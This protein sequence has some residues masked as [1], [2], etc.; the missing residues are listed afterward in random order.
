MGDRAR[1]ARARAFCNSLGERSLTEPVPAGVAGGIVTLAWSLVSGQHTTMYDL[2][3]DT[4][5]TPRR[6]LFVWGCLLLCTGIA[7]IVYLLTVLL[8]GTTSTTVFGVFFF[9][10]AGLHDV[11]FD[12][13][14]AVREYIEDEIHSHVGGPAYF[15]WPVG[16]G[17]D[18]LHD[19]DL[20]YAHAH[21]EGLST[22]ILLRG[23]MLRSLASIAG[24]VGS[25]GGTEKAAARQGG[26]KGGDD[27]AVMGDVLQ[28]M[29]VGWR[30]PECWPALSLCWRAYV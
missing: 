13:A 14:T 25:S 23:R 5:G 1:D 17:T 16:G 8:V 4:R 29:Q 21:G 19:D 22:V 15:G 18:R 6:P 30:G 24:L 2:D 12:G 3:L 26:G 7:Y 27:D 11:A 28:A 9:L 20:S 10:Y